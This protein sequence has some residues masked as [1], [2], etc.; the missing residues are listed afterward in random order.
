LVGFVFTAAALKFLP[1]WLVFLILLFFPYINNISEIDLIVSSFVLASVLTLKLKRRILAGS[2]LGFLSAVTI[3]YAPGQGGLATLAVVAGTAFASLREPKS[4]LY[5]AIGFLLC[6]LTL[7]SAPIVGSVYW[8][9]IRYG[10]EQ[11]Q[12]NSVANGIPWGLTF[13]TSSFNGMAFEFIR[14]FWIFVPILLILFLLLSWNKITPDPVQLALGIS[15]AI[16]TFLFIFR[17]LGRIDPGFTRMGIASTWFVI[18]IVPLFFY[19][20]FRDKITLIHAAAWLVFSGLLIPQISVGILTDDPYASIKRNLS[21]IEVS[22]VSYNEALSVSREFPMIGNQLV[23]SNKIF[24]VRELRTVTDSL[25]QKSETYLDLSNRSANYT[26]L[27]RVPPIS[28]PAIY[29]LVSEGQQSRAVQSLTQNKPPLIL[30]SNTNI[31]HDGGPIGLRSP[32][33]YSWV[34]SQL[35][36]YQ[37]MKKGSHVW[38]VKNSLETKA[39]GIGLVSIP[40]EDTIVELSQVWSLSDLA[41][42]AASYGASWN[43]LQNKTLLLSQQILSN[44]VANNLTHSNELK[45]EIQPFTPYAIVNE[46]HVLKF[47]YEC[48]SKADVNTELHLGWVNP[49]SN[50]VERRKLVFEVQDGTVVV[51]LYAS[52]EWQLSKQKSSFFVFE[53]SEDSNCQEVRIDSLELRALN[54]LSHQAP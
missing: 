14:S 8:G 4:L 28:V 6:Q 20:I 41:G 31:M 39:Q 23:D 17:A 30:I 18:V 52:I 13:G 38:L 51:P 25:L 3:M 19:V 2:I 24:E 33:L 12:M 22:K 7:V 47:R 5:R 1:T 49:I 46:M 34:L 35:P 32:Y 45:L 26:Y 44:S 11:S 10:L 53:L 9:A 15:L 27:N 42:I 37:L 16:L 21:T 36:E 54:Q 29:N 43:T 48:S 40:D 50:T